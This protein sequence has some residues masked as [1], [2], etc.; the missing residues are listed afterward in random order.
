MWPRSISHTYLSRDKYL[1]QHCRERS[2][3]VY[4]RIISL[5]LKLSTWWESIKKH[6]M[7][8]IL[9]R[10]ICPRF[11]SIATLKP[12]KKERS[13]TFVSQQESMS[14]MLTWS[15]KKISQN[16]NMCFTI[17]RKA[18][19]IAMCLLSMEMTMTKVKFMKMM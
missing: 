15:I 18:T 2:D 8:L 17:C 3:R 1:T 10:R 16:F 12:R 4:Q 11:N 13:R 6:L 19:K 7:L 9:R 5:S 14:S